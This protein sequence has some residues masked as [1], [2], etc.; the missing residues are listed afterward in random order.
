MNY[1]EFAPKLGDW[2]ESLRP[3]IEGPECDAIYAKLKSDRSRGKK[4]VPLSENTFRA[5][6]ETPIDKVK[7]VWFAYDPYPWV[8]EVY[9]E[10]KKEEIVV[11]DGIAFSCANI[12]ILQPSLELFYEGIEE[13]LYKGLHLKMVKDPDLAYLC[14]QGIMMT[15]SA[16]TTEKNK[17]GAHSKLWQPFM[18]YL[19]EE[20]FTKLPGGI[21]F[22]LAGKESQKLER[23]INTLQHHI[24][25]VEHPAAASHADRKWHH[26]NVFSK[27]NKALKENYGFEPNWALE[28]AP[29]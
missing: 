4:S 22:V 28:P 1:E 17:V 29:F 15:N 25:K 11:A 14:N 19:L 23:W 21:I 10:G 7:V 16:L 8:K 18:K 3:F 9:N 27:I 13:D 2:A 26:D 12:G 24:I 20:V 6:L 5:F